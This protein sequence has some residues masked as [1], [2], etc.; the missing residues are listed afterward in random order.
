[1]SEILSKSA[2]LVDMNREW[3]A[4]G[5]LLDR[6]SEA[7]MLTSGVTGPW[8]VKHI[9]SHITFWEKAL[10]DLIESAVK[11]TPLKDPP[12]TNDVDVDRANLNNYL[13]NR[14]RSLADV[15]LEFRDVYQELL[16][17]IQGL[18]EAELTGPVPFDWASDDLRLWQIIVANTTDHYQEHRLEIEKF[19]DL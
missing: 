14:E 17:V 19:F 4:L 7:Q 11:G 16:T 1:M 6:L 10:L 13:E 8:S 5:Q 15:R 9:L 2:I 3:A 12:I 18:D